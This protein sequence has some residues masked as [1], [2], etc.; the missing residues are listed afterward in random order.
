MPI[1]VVR[2]IGVGS[3]DLKAFAVC[4]C[5]VSGKTF[6]NGEV[7]VGEAAKGARNV[8]RLRDK[9]ALITVT[10]EVVIFLVVATHE[11][12]GIDGRALVT[13]CRLRR[14]K[15]STCKRSVGNRREGSEASLSRE[16]RL[17]IR[18][19]ILI[20]GSGRCRAYS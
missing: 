3:E 5:K 7:V 18:H 8:E 2:R 17:G 14:W 13:A 4:R 20:R 1:R 6:T 16:C 9:E 10:M 15:Y 19:C 11:C 12:V